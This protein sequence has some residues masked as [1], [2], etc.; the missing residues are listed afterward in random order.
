MLVN[1]FEINYHY[2]GKEERLIIFVLPI[3]TIIVIINLIIKN[4]RFLQRSQLKMMKHVT[5]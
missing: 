5:C 4:V 3:V 2:V 1:S